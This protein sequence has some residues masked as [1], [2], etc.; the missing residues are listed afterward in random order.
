MEKL[1]LKT[2]KNQRGITLVA[3]VITIV[4]LLILAGIAIASLTGD[5][6]LFARARQAR[7]ETLI[8]QEDELRRLTMLEAAANLENQLYTD[9][10]GDTATIPAGFAVSQVEGENTIEDGLV[11]IDKS[12]NEFVWVPVEFDR[13]LDNFAEIFI[14]REG[15]RS[16]DIQSFLQN[17]GEADSSGI[18]HYFDENSMQ[19]TETTKQ[20]AIDLYASVKKYA[21][22]YIGRYETGK[23]NGKAVIKKGIDVYNNVPWSRNGKMNEDDPVLAEEIDGIDNGAIEISRNFD[24]E[25]NYIN[26]K[27][28]LA[29]GVQ[30]DAIIKWIENIPNL[31]EK[32]S[33][34]VY[35]QDSTDMGWYSDNYLDKNPEHKTGI[36]LNDKSNKVKNIYDLAGNVA[37]WTMESYNTR[38]R[39]CRGGSHIG[40]GYT[41]PVS[42]RTNLV[43]YNKLDTLGFRIALY[44]Y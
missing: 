30:R 35:I 10:N 23:E 28:T 22:F 1:N 29:Y 37:E 13:K 17:C 15:Y 2:Q 14:R 19:E 8:A 9:K 20:E 12:G 44:I 36:D 3:L 4:I 5:N 26:V 33:L 16:G 38:Y 27:S 25:N 40:S 43:P 34:K 39:I 6:G 7:E 41:D 21:G 31:S 11:I 24:E 42:C 18:N 32:A